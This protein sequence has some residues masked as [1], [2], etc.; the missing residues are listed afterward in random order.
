MFSS[1]TPKKSGGAVYS[2]ITDS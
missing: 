1:N 2:E